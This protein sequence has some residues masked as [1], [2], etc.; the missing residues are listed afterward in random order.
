MKKIIIAALCLLCAISIVIAQRSMAPNAPKAADAESMF[1]QI[2]A[3]EP[4][5]FDQ[6]KQNDQQY[7]QAYMAKRQEA[8]TKVMDL[9]QQF[10]ERFPDHPQAMPLMMQ[11]WAFMAQQ[12]KI[13]TV[14]DE[15]D[16][17]LAK[18][19]S[20][21]AKTDVLF[22]RAYGQMLAEDQPSSKSVT[23]IDEFIKAAPKDERGG[24]LLF[25][26]AESDT[27]TTKQVAA[28]KRIIEQYPNAVAAAQAKGMLRQ[29]EGI[30]KPFELSFTDAISGKQIDVQKDLKGKI[31]LIDFWATWCGPCVA[32]MPE[33]KKTYEQY[34]AK[35]VEFIGVSLDEPETSGGLTKLKAFV[36]DNQI[37]WPQYYQGKQWESEFSRGW[38]ITG[39]PA[40][41]LIDA[42]GKLA[43]TQ[44]RGKLDQLIPE[45]I[46]KRDAKK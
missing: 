46:A 27:D 44:A 37:P 45:L 29:S 26:L 15:T 42:D 8:I 24:E 3:I 6:S 12:G 22:I 9:T 4:P 43:N 18:Q 31:V 33:M 17:I 7:I 11:R 5:A 25:H 19:I 16:K 39:I 20:P 2:T 35:G 38:G 30:G 32:E 1:K 28:Y 34:K 23:A 10:Y 13:A 36:K 14:M 41:F 40:N 21:E